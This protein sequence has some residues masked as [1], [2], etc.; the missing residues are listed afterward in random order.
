[1]T[2]HSPVLIGELCDFQNGGT[3]SRAVEQ[4]FMGDLPWITGADITSPIVTTARSFITA[5]ALHNSAATRVSAGTVLLVTRTSVGKVAVAGVD[6]A[7]SQDITALSAR[8]G[9]VHTP[10]LVSY[11]RSKQEH[12][13][14]QGR[15]ATIKG[16][17][18]EVVAKLKIPLPPLPEQ[19]RIADILDK[20]DALRAQRRVALAE[21]DSLTQSIFLDLFGDPVANPFGWPLV[22]ADDLCERVT[23]GIVVQPASY[24]QQSGVPALRSLN[25]RPNKIRMENLV[26][27]SSS[28]NETKLAKTR[29]RAGDVLLVRSGQPGTA[30]V[31]PSELD[32]VNAIDLLI[33]TPNTA[34]VDPSYLCF[35]FNSDGGK[36]MALGAQRGQVQKHLNVGSLKEAPIPIP[37]LTLQRSFARR[38]T[39]IETLK[40]RHRAALAELD[41]LFASL[42][43]RAFRGEL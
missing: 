12:L 26:Y 24:Y 1:M 16:I 7:F 15:G 31:V 36:R 28:D 25:I 22:S 6:L 11:L 20:A 37:P 10:Y 33:A 3:P 27:F 43:H 30:A 42:Q 23:V 13:A 35:Y 8:D 2:A 5:E 32:G 18:R 39:A 4:Y 19:R 17:T 38:I 34:K 14:S 41:T 21:L 40:S 9:M 29:V